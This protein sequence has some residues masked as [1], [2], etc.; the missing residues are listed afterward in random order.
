MTRGSLFA[1]GGGGGDGGGGGEGGGGD[2]VSACLPHSLPLGGLAQYGPSA[3]LCQ[4][5]PRHTLTEALP[6]SQSACRVRRTRMLRRPGCS[7]AT[8][9][10]ICRREARMPDKTKSQSKRPHAHE[11]L[12]WR[13]YLRDMLKRHGADQRVPTCEEQPQCDATFAHHCPRASGDVRSRTAPRG[14]RHEDSSWSRGRLGK[15]EG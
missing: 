12:C 9:A 13:E 4:K 10:L 15:C 6:R 2:G 7:S 1:A 3:P 5:E 14:Q 8:S 11:Q